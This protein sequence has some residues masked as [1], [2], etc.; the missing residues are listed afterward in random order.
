MQAVKW[1]ATFVLILLSFFFLWGLLDQNKDFSMVKRRVVT[2]KPMIVT[3]PT[4]R[5]Y[6]KESL[7]WEFNAATS[8]FYSSMEEAYFYEI[9][10]SIFSADHQVTRIA[11][12]LGIIETT[13]NIVTLQENIS[14]LL[15][16]GASLKTEELFLDR[17]KKI[18]YNQKKVTYKSPRIEIEGKNMKINLNSMQLEL[19]NPRIH[20]QY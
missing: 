17:D 9:K 13:K 8:A 16:D 19:K 14:V 6:K 5:E 18:L 2:E 11:A 15:P 20:I 4:F 3:N 7:K 1:I 10:G 12:G